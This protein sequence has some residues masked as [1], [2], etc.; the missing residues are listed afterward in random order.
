MGWTAGRAAS[1]SVGVAS[2]RRRRRLLV[3]GLLHHP[4]GDCTG[5]DLV[6]RGVG[7]NPT[8]TG[9]LDALLQMGARIAVRAERELSGEPV[10]D[11]AIEYAPLTGIAVGSDLALRAIDEVPL[12]AIAAAFAGGE[13]TINGVSAC[14][15]RSRIALRASNAC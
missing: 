10:A 4:R 5:S 8:R 3:G 6:V 15:P 9:L 12:L 2:D 1:Q 11:V 7:V 14:A 13:T